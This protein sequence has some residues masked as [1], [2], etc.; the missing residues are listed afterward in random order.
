M[1]MATAELAS[2]SE[3]EKLGLFERGVRAVTDVLV[4]GTEECQVKSRRLKKGKSWKGI[5]IQTG[6][7]S[8]GQ[9]RR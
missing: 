7:H 9:E 8:R 2:I 5:E 4:L 1:R 3:G 6:E